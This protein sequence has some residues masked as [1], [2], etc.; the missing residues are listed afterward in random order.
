MS[1]FCRS[2]ASS[3]LLAAVVAAA[4]CVV[5]VRQV[6]VEPLEPREA[7]VSVRSPVRAHLADGSMIVYSHG[8]TVERDTVRGFGR[9]Y[10]LTLAEVGTV[11]AFPLDSIVGMESFRAGVDERATTA[12][13]VPA[14]VIGTAAGMLAAAG[15]F[16]ALFGSCPTIYSESGGEYHLEAEAFSYSIAPLFEARGADVLRAR[17]GPDG[18]LTLEVRNE[19]LE[20]HY[21][22]HLEV[23]EVRHRAG[24]VVVPDPLGRAVALSR[25]V[26]PT[27]IVDR[28]GRDL[29]AMLSRPEAVFE[30]D[31]RTL[32]RAAPGDYHDHIDLTLPAPPGADSVAVVFRMR[33]SL[34]S[35]V[36]F[37]DVMLAGSGA[38]A[39]DWLGEDLQQIGPALE[40]GQWFASRMGLRVSVWEDG[41]YREV[42]RIP[43]PGPIAWKQVA[44]VV[45][46]PA[47]ETMRV[48]LSF[49]ADGWR[50]DELRVAASVA[51]PAERTVVAARVVDAE[52]NDDPEALA[53]VRDSD[54]RYLQ[55][56]AGQRF[57]ID[58][59]V[60]DAADGEG[61]TYLL[62]S[63]GYYIEWMRSQWLREGGSGEPFTPSDEAVLAAMALWR[64]KQGEMEERF[65]ATKIPVR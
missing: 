50:I 27:S 31:P 44:A 63:Q 2:V 13:S 38:R 30:T 58:F 21:I 32:D 24:E 16:V 65:E 49:V 17:P 18:V 3:L 57:T 11:D 47:G 54:D 4:A 55:T 15:L 19:A 62:A 5:T 42:G 53:A 35:T 46:V 51:R 36:L 10:D 34:L 64:T 29:R 40:L 60:G 37:Y 39:L 48:R 7:Q 45:P 1:P 52:G 14:T 6:E 25:F 41:A 33:N 56:T 43:E 20:T 8:L 26:E 9:R 22:N 59:D 12:L 28:A 23:L 61:R